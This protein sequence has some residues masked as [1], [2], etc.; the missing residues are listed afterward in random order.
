[1]LRSDHDD[2]V[3]HDVVDDGNETKEMSDDEQS[4][5]EVCLQ[6][7]RKDKMLTPKILALQKSRGY[8]QQKQQLLTADEHKLITEQSAIARL[9]IDSDIA[10]RVEKEKL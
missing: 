10:E 3:V 5:D 6:Q 7:R 2:A 9:K 1:M 4:H 8:F